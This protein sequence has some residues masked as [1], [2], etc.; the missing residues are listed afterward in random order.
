M[1]RQSPACLSHGTPSLTVLLLFGVV[2][3]PPPAHTHDYT[4]THTHLA[5][6]DEGRGN[7]YFFTLGNDDTEDA[8]RFSF[9]EMATL[10]SL[11]MQ[12]GNTITCRV[13]YVNF[14]VVTQDHPCEVCDDARTHRFVH[15][16][17][18]RRAWIVLRAPNTNTHMR[19]DPMH[20]L[21]VHIAHG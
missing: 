9:D 14:K 1:C 15:R 3:S 18:N 5:P 8:F 21:P 20:A 10:G 11:G 7:R 19:A 13:V 2:A 12:D 6:Q 4:H 16:V 17:D